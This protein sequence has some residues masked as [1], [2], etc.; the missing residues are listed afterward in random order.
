MKSE[1]IY[2]LNRLEKSGYKAS[3]KYTMA[4]NLDDIKFEYDTIK[5]QRDIDKSIKFSRK[6]LLACISGVEFLNNKFDYM[7][8]KL[9]G[10][11]EQ[12]MESVGDYD[13]VFEELHDKY[14]E[15][16][17]MAPELK[18]LMMVAG[19]GFM[20]HLTQ[21]LFKSSTPEV[22]DILRQ[23]P[24]IMQSI[25]QAAM[26]NMSQQFQQTTDNKDPIMNMMMGGIKNSIEKIDTNKKT[27][28]NKEKNSIDNILEQLDND[29]N[30][31]KNIKVNNRTKKKKGIDLDI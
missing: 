16:V 7:D 6:M 30:I 26:N 13:E 28:L 29:D 21:S 24:D 18:L 27:N 19:S 31:M 10:W 17:K 15:K 4:S 11:S 12:T 3:R 8:L 9:D 25:S 2:K 14:N 5:R 20:F 1:L 23:N 22:N